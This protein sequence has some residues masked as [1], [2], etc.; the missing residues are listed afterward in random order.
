MV[1][2]RNSGRTLASRGAGTDL[3]PPR[4]GS[5]SLVRGEVVLVGADVAGRKSTRILRAVGARD[6]LHVAIL[7]R[8]HDLL[9]DA[10][11]LLEGV[12]VP[13]LLAGPGRVLV[14]GL[15]AVLVRVLVVLEVSATAEDV[16]VLVGAL[17]VAVEHLEAAR[18]LV[19]VAVAPHAQRRRRVLDDVPDHA[20]DHEEREAEAA[21]PAHVHLP[22]LDL[23]VRHEAHAQE[24][25]RQRAARVRRETLARRVEAPPRDDQVCRLTGTSSC[26]PRGLCYS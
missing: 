14:P 7:A 22:L 8:V 18:D 1:L 17:D 11:A 19:L 15:Q 10:V 23:E 12:L 24:E 4:A 21:E 6:L 5:D 13:P 9:A 20:E 25:A 16:V 2:L 26:R 3:G